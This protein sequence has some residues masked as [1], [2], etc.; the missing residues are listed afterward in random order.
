MIVAMCASLLSVIGLFRFFGV[1]E[2]TYNVSEN[3]GSQDTNLDIILIPY[4]SL[5][6]AILVMLFLLFLSKIFRK[7]K[8]KRYCR[9]FYRGELP[10]SV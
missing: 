3:N 9:E 10:R 2:V 6:I 7:R 8:E 1:G 4:A 5:A